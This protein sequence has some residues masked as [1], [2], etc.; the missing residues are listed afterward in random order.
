MAHPQV[1]EEVGY[2]T[3][4]LEKPGALWTGY[5]QYVRA[6]GDGIVGDADVEEEFEFVEPM[7]WPRMRSFLNW[8]RTVLAAL[9]GI[10][11]IGAALA[12]GIPLLL[13]KVI[14]PLM[15]WEAQ[16][17]SKPLVALVALASMALFPAVL[18]PVGPFMWLAGIVFG[19][20]GGVLL[21]LV[22]CFFGM[23]L[24]YF[25]GHWL[26]HRRVQAWLATRPKNAALLRMA[27]NGGW[28]HQFRV[29]VLLR[30]SPFPYSVFN[31][32]IT[33]TRIKYGPYIAGSIGRL[34]KTLSD[35]HQQKQRRL[36]PVEIV[37]EAL[38]LCVAVGITIAGTWYGR[39]ALRELEQEE[40]AAQKLVQLAAVQGP[41]HV[42]GLR[43]VSSWSGGTAASATATAAPSQGPR[44]AGRAAGGG[45]EDAGG[46]RI[47]TWK[48]RGSGNAREGGAEEAEAEAE[49]EAEV[50]EE[51]RRREQIGLTRFRSMQG[52]ES[53]RLR[54]ERRRELLGAEGESCCVVEDVMQR[55]RGGLQGGGALAAVGAVPASYTRWEA[56]S[57]RDGP[58]GLLRGASSG[59]EGTWDAASCSS[60]PER[61][62]GTGGDAEGARGSILRSPGARRMKAKVSDGDMPPPFSGSNE[63]VRSERGPALWPG[64]DDEPHMH[65]GGG[66]GSGSGRSSSHQG[67]TGGK[68]LE[69][70][71]LL[72]LQQ[73]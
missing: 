7:G 10:A 73:T 4:G 5:Q 11:L 38:G 16:H 47:G 59:S 67:G 46:D 63:R 2:A 52:E 45:F 56:L 43:R 12:F 18:L 23:T 66:S 20:A 53:L 49:D 21:I 34:L 62:A 29:V 31:Y 28:L 9:A 26:L 42:S 57:E 44:A 70:R 58:D 24:P 61:W 54:E 1:D 60:S 33:A 41:P 48:G 37:Y 22:G 72:K 3:S 55:R 64:G 71:P 13:E 17:L 32:A 6:G 40:A 27:E 25:L 36:T 65:G 69:K 50:E 15:Q 39:R 8:T 14:V 68:L 19:Y 51:W 35:A 30:M